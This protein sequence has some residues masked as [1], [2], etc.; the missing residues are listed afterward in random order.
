MAPRVDV[1]FDY[2]NVHMSGHRMFC[3][4]G[5]EVHTCQFTPSVVADA[6]V[7]ARAPGGVVQ[8]IR[9]FRGRPDP[10]K[11][12]NLTRYW[13]KRAARWRLDPRVM[14]FHR[15]LRYPADF[16]EAGCVEKVREKGIDVGLAVDLLD[17]AIAHDFDVAIVFSH[18]TD[19]IPAFE[20]ADKRGAHIELAGWQGANVIRGPAIK[21]RH[22]LDEAVFIAAREPV[23]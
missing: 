14:M 7:A 15:P 4:P 13:D 23:L 21:W 19:L 6:V 17:R 10:R 22:V 20:L 3:P 18:D 5:S 2:Q 8:S 11:E 12:P 16:G 1:F 9:V